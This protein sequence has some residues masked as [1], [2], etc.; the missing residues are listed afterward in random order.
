MFLDTLD[1]TKEFVTMGNYSNKKILVTGGT[2]FIGSRLSERLAYEE[3][4]DVTVLVHNWNKATWV[5]R[6]NVNLVQGNVLNDCDLD[7]VL[8]ECEIVFHCVGIGGSYEQCMKTNF[9]GTKN[10]LNASVRNNVKKI[11]YLSS[12]VVHGPEIT[13]GMNEDS[14]FIKSGNPYADSKIEAEKYF[15]DFISKHEIEGTV[16][17]P[18]FV[19]GPVSPYYSIDPVLKMKN[20]SFL[21]VDKGDGACNAVH[22]DTVVDLLILCGAHPNANNETFLITDGENILWREFWGYYAKMVGQDISKF[23][24]VPLTDNLLRSFILRLKHKTQNGI[25]NISIKIDKHGIQNPKLTRY[26]LKAPRK[27]LKLVVTFLND[28]VPEMDDW[29]R[30]SYGSKGYVNI[31]KA[32]NLLGFK[33]SKSLNQNMMDMELWLRDQRYIN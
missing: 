26:A 16:L 5:S 3:H 29:D 8:S 22:V 12:V 9:E 2:G 6:A 13:E 23:A 32:K 28:L 18:T 15:I 17:R 33:K 10:V 14:P 11:V 19:W 31:G 1:I 30:I 21:L 4:A 24:S 25:E 7:K 27:L 20:S